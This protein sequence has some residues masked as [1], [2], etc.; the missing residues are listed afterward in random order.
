MTKHH[1]K[2]NTK[3][4]VRKRLVAMLLASI[5]STACSQSSPKAMDARTTPD[6][7]TMSPLAPPGLADSAFPKPARGVASIVS[8]SWDNE[9]DR[10]R[11]GEADTVMAVLGIRTGMSVADIGAGS[12]YYTMRVAA[13]VGPRGRVYAE[14]ITP[15][16]LRDLRARVQKAG[17]SNVT[18][19]SGDPSDPRLGPQSVDRALLIHM[20]HEIRQPFGLL[21]NLYP[22]LRPGARIGIV[23]LN[24]AT[25]AHGTPPAQ[26]TCE[27]TAAGYD[28]VEFRALPEGYLAVFTPRERA[29]PAM[30]RAALAAK[31]C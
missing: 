13:R 22:A 8:P 25:Y 10:D 17:L 3:H 15:S 2:H 27:L 24:R 29:S 26:L 11:V 19:V 1:T 16:Y 7:Q 9:D 28:Q 5:A 18:L 21:Y 31:K 12:G 14:D 6:A 20:Y 30:I 4:H 23:D